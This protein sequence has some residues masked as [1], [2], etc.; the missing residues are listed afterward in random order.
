[1]TEMY[2]HPTLRES[3]HSKLLSRLED[4]RDSRLILAVQYESAR[5]AK[6]TK[7]KGKLAEQWE[8]INERNRL[9]IVKLDELID[10]RDCS[11]TKQVSISHQPAIVETDV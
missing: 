8:T 6:N 3:E 11:I 1:M 7:M 2:S 4:I 5:K 9:A 10:K